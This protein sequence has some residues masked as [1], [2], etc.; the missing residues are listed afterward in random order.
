MRKY[1]LA[2]PSAKLDVDLRDYADII[3]EA[4]RAIMP[5]AA[6][7]VEQTCY[8][9]DPTPKQGEAIK[10]GRQICQSGL[11]RHCIHIPKL[12]TSIEI[13]EEKPNGTDKPKRT[14]GHR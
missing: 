13:K 1:T 6:V 5:K 14:G 3:T 10:I 7:K 9:V 12:F 4:V 11:S 2:S 8:T